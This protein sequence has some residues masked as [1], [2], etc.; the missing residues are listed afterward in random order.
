M[1][2]LTEGRFGLKYGWD[3][4]ESGWKTGWDAN[5]L[6]LGRVGVH[7][8]IIDRDLTA[9]P[10]S[11]STDDMYIPAATATGDWVG[12]EDD[13]VIWD[14]SSWVAYTPRLGWG[15]YIEDEAVLCVF[16]TVWGTGISIT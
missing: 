5:L 16:T 2:E 1:A 13:I 6:K 8:S 11:P 12:L 9:P 3:L 14:G 15:I 7:T 4:G 10:G